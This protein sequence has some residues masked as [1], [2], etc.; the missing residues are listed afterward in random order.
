MLFIITKKFLLAIKR[1]SK[2]LRQLESFID[3]DSY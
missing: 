3:K 1:Q 2:R